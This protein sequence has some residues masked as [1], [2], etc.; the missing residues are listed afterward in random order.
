M[1]STKRIGAAIICAVV[2]FSAGAAFAQGE[3]TTADLKVMA[4]TVWVLMAIV[5]ATLGVRVSPEEEHL[6][7]DQSEMGME[8]YP[9]DV[10]RPAFRVAEEA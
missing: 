1:F 5:A 4:D 2:F 6:G 10:V 3:L 7:L 9:N 8:A